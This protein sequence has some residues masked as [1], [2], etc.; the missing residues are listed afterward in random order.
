MRSLPLALL[1]AL[2]AGTASAQ[3]PVIEFELSGSL[4]G[5]AYANQ[6]FLSFIADSEDALDS[7]DAFELGSIN[8][9]YVLLYTV[10]GPN[11]GA[12]AGT[13]LDIDSRPEPTTEAKVFL[14]GVNAVAGF[15]PTAAALA[16]KW[17]ELSNI[18]PGWSI[19]LY[20]TVTGTE[21]NVF[22]AQRYT[23]SVAADEDASQRFVLTVGPAQAAVTLTALLEG[24]YDP[25]TGR[26]RTDLSADLSLT[27]P[28]LGIVTVPT[29]Y[30]TTD[31]TG[32][33][34]VDWVLVE[35]R[36]GDPMT[37]QTI[38]QQSPALLRDDGAILSATTGGTVGFAGLSAGNY[39]VVVRHRNH[40]AAMSLAAQSLTPG[41]TMAYDFTTTLSQAYGTAPMVLASDGAAL[42]W[43]G[44]GNGDG[45]VT[46]PDFN[47]YSAATASGATGYELAD[48][49]L[50]GQ[51]TAPDFNRYSAN[52]AAGAASGVPPP[53][54]GS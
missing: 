34:I 6:A 14:L 17:P 32:Q 25:G 35:I 1:L 52:T 37:G 9:D 2:L 44:D 41:T 50:D 48:Y 16:I 40:L 38:V 39:Y 49:T 27:D 15:A 29:D 19:L 22:A 13:S 28:Y 5:T 36:T 21:V 42:L 11:A 20:D 54:G 31:A 33:R 51:V 30:F 4:G 24:A 8:G 7:F 46:A 26:M 18:P 47:A 43:A 3:T 23:F 10:L 12:D 53:S 45:Q